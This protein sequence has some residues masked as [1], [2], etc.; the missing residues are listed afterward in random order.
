MTLQHVYDESGRETAVIVPVEQWLAIVAE[1]EGEARL[2]PEDE[3]Q[4]RQA[5]EELTQGAALNLREAMAG[6]E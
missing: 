2:S 5:Y 1:L 3:S 6:W 4:R